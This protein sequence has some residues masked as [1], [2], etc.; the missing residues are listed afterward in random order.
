M[1]KKSKKLK[2]LFSKHKLTNTN[3][4]AYGMTMTKTQTKNLNTILK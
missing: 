3:G 4:K 2:I 1:M